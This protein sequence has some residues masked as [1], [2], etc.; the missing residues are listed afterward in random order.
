MLN[1]HL[2]DV[3]ESEI[4]KLTQKISLERNGDVRAG[5]GLR[6]VSLFTALQ[7]SESTTCVPTPPLGG[8]TDLHNTS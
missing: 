5:A 6:G 7:R 1:L 3:D 2:W 8:T 4:L